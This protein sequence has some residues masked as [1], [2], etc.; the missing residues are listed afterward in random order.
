MAVIFG[1]IIFQ[2]PAELPDF[3]YM[4]WAGKTIVVTMVI[5]GGI[6]LHYSG[7]FD[8]AAGPEDPYLRGLAEH[9]SQE[10]AVIYGAFW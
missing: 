2:R 3:N 5:I 9:L 4:A 1:V 10:K 7:V 6:H 8:S